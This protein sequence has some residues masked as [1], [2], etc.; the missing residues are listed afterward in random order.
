MAEL[1]PLSMG[2]PILQEWTVGAKRWQ[3][4]VRTGWTVWFCVHGRDY[5]G[6]DPNMGT[7][8]GVCA[9]QRKQDPSVKESRQALKKIQDCYLGMPRNLKLPPTAYS[10]DH[11]LYSC[12]TS[13]K[14]FRDMQQYTS[15][16]DME[17]SNYALRT[18]GTSSQFLSSAP[19]PPGP[20]FWSFP[21]RG[22]I[23]S[24]SFVA[25]QTCKYTY[26]SCT[27]WSTRIYRSG[28][29]HGSGASASSP[30][31]SL[32]VVT[33]DRGQLLTTSPPS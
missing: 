20:S 4:Q 10:M 2:S 22:Y 25:L 3:W 15:N 30:C 8:D 24:G 27:W 19:A 11:G 9:S 31:P 12:K 14:H 16:S 1:R 18:C 29:L 17:I 6:S 32:T 26:V 13:L 23:W 33:V 5:S 21:Y 7:P 28:L